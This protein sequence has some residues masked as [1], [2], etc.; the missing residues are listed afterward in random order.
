MVEGNRVVG[1]AILYH[2]YS[3][4]NM[5]NKNLQSHLKLEPTVLLKR[6]RVCV[7][8]WHQFSESFFSLS[9][10]YVSLNFC[11]STLL[12]TPKNVNINVHD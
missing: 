1:W 8:S 3:I 5:N 7:I 12:D 9:M 11:Y 4:K 2:D 10:S 6:S